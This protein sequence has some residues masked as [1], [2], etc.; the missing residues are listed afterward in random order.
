MNLEP[1]QNS[2]SELSESDPLLLK[3]NDEPIYEFVGHH[4]IASYLDC[5][6]KALRD[7]TALISAVITAVESSGATVL[8]IAEHIFPSGGLTAVI[9]LAESH[10]SIH[11]YPENNSCF[12]DL[13]TCG[14]SCDATKFEIL[15][16]RYLH[17]KKINRQLLVRN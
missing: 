3:L 16:K 2:I 7:K 11:T 14:H 5:D 15:L 4:L 12:I 6:K 9:L 8:K 17:P 10:A 1:G 13:F